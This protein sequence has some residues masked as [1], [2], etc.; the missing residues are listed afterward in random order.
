MFLYK[1]RKSVREGGDGGG[2]AVTES[3][4]VAAGWAN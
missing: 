1:N 3:R 4:V 2:A